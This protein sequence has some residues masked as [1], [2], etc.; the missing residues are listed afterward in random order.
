[1]TKA[2]PTASQIIASALKRHGVEV[3]FGQRLPSTVIL[4]GENAFNRRRARMNIYFACGH[5][6]AVRVI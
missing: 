1:M 6:A 4:A 2:A 5:P 3:I